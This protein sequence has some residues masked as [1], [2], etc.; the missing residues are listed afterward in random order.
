MVI[1]WIWFWINVTFPMPFKVLHSC[2]SD[3]EDLNWRLSCLWVANLFSPSV[4]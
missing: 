4:T 1:K 2:C 3:K